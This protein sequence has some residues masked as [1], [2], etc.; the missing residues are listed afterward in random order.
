MN[1][2]N[3]CLGS[4][5]IENTK[6]TSTYMNKLVH[7]Y[8]FVDFLDFNAFSSLGS[9]ICVYINYLYFE[10][11]IILRLHCYYIFTILCESENSDYAIDD[12]YFYKL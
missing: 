5:P 7:N 8:N 6:G 3:N 4:F 9:F 11:K 10:C 1:V 12:Y 2:L